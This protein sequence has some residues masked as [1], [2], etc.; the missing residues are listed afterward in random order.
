M[1]VPTLSECV[2][3]AGGSIN[4][5]L[6]AHMLL[7]RFNCTLSENMPPPLIRLADVKVNILS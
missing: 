6:F 5:N 1:T 4:F 2:I 3:F 7:G